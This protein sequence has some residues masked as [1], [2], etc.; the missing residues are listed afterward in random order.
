MSIIKENISLLQLNTFHIDTTARY[1]VELFNAD[2][3]VEFLKSD[4]SKIRPRL[5]L[6]AGSNVLFVSNFEGVIIQPLIK[7]IEKTVENKETLFIRAGAGENWDSF[8]EYCVEKELGGIENLS[9]IPGTV[10]ATPVQN[11]GAYG[12]EVKDVIDSVEAVRLDDGRTIRLKAEECRFSYRDSIFKNEL[13]DRVIITHVT[14]RLNKK[15]HFI[16]RYADLEKELDNYSETSIHTI[17]QAIISIRRKKLPDPAIIGNAGSFFKNPVVSM[18]KV[19]SIRSSYPSMPGYDNKNG[20]VKL[21]AAWL[22]EQCGWKGKRTG[23]TG[24]YQ[25][26]PLIVVNHGKADGEE[27][28]NCVLKIQKV[29][30]NNFGIKLEMEVNVIRP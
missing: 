6:G 29:V 16:T 8:V 24:T 9:L 3:I 25:K 1:L 14:Y 28:L 11:I 22:I 23:N 30:M 26:Q 18:D 5:I 21:S 17:R 19:K 2:E 13:R 12:V 7:G 4:L 10:G 15:H 27:I 20:T